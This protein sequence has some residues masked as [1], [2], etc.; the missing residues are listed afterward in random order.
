[1]LEKCFEKDKMNIDIL[2][3]FIKTYHYLSLDEKRDVCVWLDKG[4]IKEPYSYNVVW[5]E[6][7]ND[8]KLARILLQIWRQNE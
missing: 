3:K 5:N 2:F 4:L 1:M 7:V 6:I 8:T